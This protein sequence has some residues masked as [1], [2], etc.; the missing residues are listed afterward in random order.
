MIE[1]RERDSSISAES[2]RL[3]LDCINAGLKLHGRVDRPGH[4]Q[5]KLTDNRSE[6]S[7]NIYE[8]KNGRTCAQSFAMVAIGR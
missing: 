3:E 6:G 5:L 2:R 8:G 7:I 1:K 4:L